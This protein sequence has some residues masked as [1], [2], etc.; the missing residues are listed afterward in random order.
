[1][2]SVCTIIVAVV[3]LAV[4]PVFA[5]EKATVVGVGFPAGTPAITP[6][7]INVGFLATGVLAGQTD[8]EHVVPC[9]NC[10]SG[11]DIQTLLIALPLG[12]VFSG[13][14]TTIIVTGDDLF[15]GGLASFSFSIKA[16]PTV[17][18]IMTES[19]E[20]DVT[21]GIWLAQFPIT[22]PAPGYYILEGQ[23]ATGE[24]LKQVTSVSSHIL[25]GAAPAN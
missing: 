14:S 11:P 12:A 9:F 19:V 18:P 16:N 1:M 7:T 17:A 2:R 10:V 24:G 4:S 20:A 6:E 3:L 5:A 25:I 13:S 8:P 21:P 22:A 23:I 15:Y